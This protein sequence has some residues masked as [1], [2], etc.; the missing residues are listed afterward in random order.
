LKKKKKKKSSQATNLIILA[1]GYFK[2]YLEGKYVLTQA[3][4]KETIKV[5]M[6]IEVGNST[7]IGK[8]VKRALCIPFKRKKIIRL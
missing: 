2:T 1:I 8:L 3:H 4:K 7:A 6:K 5:V